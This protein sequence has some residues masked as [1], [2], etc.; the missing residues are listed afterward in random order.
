MFPS[1][2]DEVMRRWPNVAF[3]TCDRFRLAELLD[4]F[5]GKGVHV[6]PRVTRWSESSDDIRAVRALALDGNLSVEPQAR[7]L[8]RVALASTVVESD[9]SGNSRLTKRG[10]NQSERDDPIAALVL[11]AGLRARTPAPVPFRLVVGHRVG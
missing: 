1:L 7:A 3:A 9:T 4:A 10:T 6:V 11:A 8:L 2:V 5:A